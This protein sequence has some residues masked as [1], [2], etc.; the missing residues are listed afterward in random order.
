MIASVDSATLQRMIARCT[1]AASRLERTRDGLVDKHQS[2]ASTWSDTK[3]RE[4]G[5]IVGDCAS[6]ISSV[7]SI[8]TDA[9]RWLGELDAHVREYESVNFTGSASDSRDTA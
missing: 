3:H 8:L 7:T 4:L 9:A 2:L 5:A 6:A 1:E